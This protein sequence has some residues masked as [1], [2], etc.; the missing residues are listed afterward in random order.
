LSSVFDEIRKYKRN[1]KSLREQLSE[2][3]ESQNSREREIS[4]TIQEIGKVINDLKT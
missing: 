3:E 4:N 1:N 2:Y